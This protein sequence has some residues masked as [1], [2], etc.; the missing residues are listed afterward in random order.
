M[1]PEN[2]RLKEN[3][4]RSKN[5]LRWGPYLS[6]RQWG[7]VRE[8]YTEH[9]HSWTA[10]PHDHAR[11]RVYRWSE[12]GLNGWSDRKGRLCFAPALWNGQDSILK[13]RLYGFGG[14]EGNHGE[15]C[16]ECYYY[17]DSTPSHSYTKV[18]YKYPQCKYP[19]TKLLEANSKLNRLERE[20][21]LTDLGVF[22]D[23]RY[24]DVVQ[25]VA[26]RTAEDVLWKI[27]ITN[28][29]TESAPAHV[30]PMV[31][32]RNIWEG[33]NKSEIPEV[34]PSMY[35]EDG[36]LKIEHETL[37]EFV[38]HVESSDD[39]PLD[40][41]LFTE[42]ETNEEAIFGRSSKAAYK[43]DAFHRYVIKHEED[44][45][46]PEQ[47]GTRAA[48]YFKLEVPAGETISI[49]CRLHARDEN[50]GFA[51][52]EE[53]EE[54]MDAR[55]REA[56]EFYCDIIPDHLAEEEKLISRQS[57]AGLLWTKQFYHFVVKDWLNHSPDGA[58]LSPRRL[59]GRN[60]DWQHIYAQDVLSMPD[61]WEYPWF[62]AWD[63]AFHMISFATVDPDFAK[64]QLLLL[65]REWYMHPNGQ[66]PAYEWNFSDVN[67]PVHAWA[68]WRVYKITGARGERDKLFLEK[69]FQKLL[70]N[71]TWWVNRKD[72]EGRHVF[73]GGFLGLDNIGVF[74]RSHALPDGS[75]LNQADGTAWMASY[76]LTMLSMALELAPENPAYGDI[77]SKFFEHFVNITDAI[78]SIGGSGLWDEEDGFYYDQLIINKK[79]PMHLKTRSL[80]GLLPLFATLTLTEGTL[81]ALPEFRK[82]LEWFLDSRPD[83]NKYICTRKAHKRELGDLTLLSVASEDQL[84]RT[85]ERMLDPDEFLSEFGIRSLSKVHEKE[86]FIFTHG[87]KTNEVR[88]TP[89]ESETDMFGGNSNWRGPIWFPTNYLLI[90][91]LER[92]HFYYGDSFKVE[93]PKGSG[94]QLNLRE[95][96]RDLCAR[97]VTLFTVG[98]DGRRPCFGDVEDYKD[99][100]E[101]QDLILYYEYFNAETG[102]GLG[103]SH[104]TG[105]TSLITHL[106]HKRDKEIERKNGN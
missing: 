40:S 72:S 105:W 65:T 84:R 46:N 36:V 34:K 37:G 28:R 38:F 101:W 79:A 71:F 82:R 4:E 87:G 104:Q 3:R 16:K 13:E 99:K 39:C 102:E 98:E 76:C 96:A 32:F 103:A 12:D 1:T 53:F 70:I 42:N 52:F 20:V 21:E 31:W 41:W 85:L 91:A 24:F 94:N 86:P 56:D 90:E 45:L 100:K 81:N 68:V 25:E 64:D 2:I 11:S 43:K 59:E 75:S 49:R 9:G 62:A 22:D 7:T 8:D 5:W 60:N 47:K 6:E 29:A 92:Y 57:Y 10:F 69:A 89:G 77:A 66:L 73:G 74:D 55:I 51:A 35:L 48:P 97:L 18:L 88:Y 93:Y 50:N 15:D 14:H 67:P 83:L 26:K 19:Y 61:K 54:T 27:S 63:S 33:G 78:N 80:V 44:V 106:I 30:L 95:V 23:N 58:P 17:L